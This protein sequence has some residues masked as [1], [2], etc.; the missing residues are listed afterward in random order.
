MVTMHDVLDAQHMY[1][2]NGDESYLRRI[3]MPLERLMINHKK[4]I[5]KDSA[6]NALCY[7]AQLMIPGVLRFSK[8]IDV[9]MVIVLVST[10]GEAIS[11]AVAQMTTPQIATCEYGTVAKTKR[12][13]MERDTYPRKWGLGPKATEKK[14]LIASGLLTKHG[15]PNEKT[16]EA[17]KASVPELK[18][19]SIPETVNAPAPAQAT[20]D[21]PVAAKKEKKKKKKKEAKVEAPPA[22]KKK[23]K[24]AKRALEG[25]DEAPK[26]KKKKAKT[27]E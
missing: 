3:I 9:G 18:K 19:G 21:E 27:S 12:V 13:I 24:K 10:K 11:T 23:K 25:A 17:W 16:P 8:D 4:I 1:D 15:R 26:K 6:V 7:G 5:V 22:E 20:V 14:K 2:N